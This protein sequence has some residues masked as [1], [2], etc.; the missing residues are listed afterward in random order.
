MAEPVYI[1]TEDIAVSAGVYAHRKGEV[2]PA[3]NVSANG[4]EAKVAKA[5]TKAASAVSEG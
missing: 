4:W 5:G 2:V 3:D 1:A